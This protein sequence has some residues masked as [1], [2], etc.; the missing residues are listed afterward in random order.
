MARYLVTGS[1]GFIGTHVSNALELANHTVIRTDIAGPADFKVDL[2]DANWGDFRMDDLEGVVHLGAKISVP[3][4]LAE[5]EQYHEVNVEA[6]RKLFQACLEEGVPRIVF[7]SSAAVYGSSEW[8]VMR[9][10][11]E[12]PPGSPY[13]ETKLRGE[14]MASEFA[15]SRT[16]FVCLRFFNVYGPG[17]PTDNAYASVIP[18]FIDLMARGL[19]VTIHGDGGQTRD[20][21][22][23]H[24]VSRTILSALQADVPACSVQN[25]GTGAGISIRGLADIL[26]EIFEDNGMVVPEVRRGPARDGDIRHSIADVSGLGALIDI[27]SFTKLQEGLSDLVRR[28]LDEAEA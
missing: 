1:S 11:E 17:Q 3:E 13:A 9:I 27:S 6:T 24:D 28:T 2:R 20:F 5:P 14:E 12:G 19:P 4:S 16:R 23:V 15:S 26:T 18:L 22:H 7:A 25:L 10:G 21:V 8:D